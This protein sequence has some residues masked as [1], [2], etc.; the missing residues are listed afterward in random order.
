M[1]NLRER[2][3]SMKP[4][5]P[6]YLQIMFTVLAFVVMVVLS[7]LFMSNIVHRELVQ[8]ANNVLS[9]G[10][11][12]IESVLQQSEAILGGF[13]QTVRRII[14]MGGGLDAL[15]EYVTEITEYLNASNML[16]MDIYG[17]GGVY[18]YF[19]TLAGYRVYVSGKEWSPPP[20]YTPRS[21]PWYMA[22]MAA[23]GSI[24]VTA[25]YED[26]ATGQLVF[27]F[28]RS[29][30]HDDGRFLGV[31][32]LD[33]PINTIAD[34]IIATALAQGGYG[35]L[36]SQ[37]MI[38]LAHPNKDLIGSSFRNMAIP[39]AIFADDLLAGVEI[40]ERRVQSFRGESAIAFFREL[41]NGWYLGLVTP[42]GPYYQSVR[43]MALILSVLGA[44]L[45]VALV[46]VLVRID[47]ARRKSSEESHK[48]S[49]FLAKMSHEMRTPLNAVIGF[50]DLTL[51][52]GGLNEEASSNISK[53]RDAGM[54]LLSTVNDILDISKIEAG[55]LGI[56]PVVY[57]TPSLLNDAITQSIM[58]IG[59]KNIKFILDISEDL[60]TRLYGDDLRVKQILN[61]L[62][63]N[64]FKYTE[65][66]TVELKVSCEREGD[67]VWLIARVSDTGAGIRSEDLGRLFLDYSQMDAAFNRK[68]EGTGLGLS[69]SK[70]VAEQMG[71]SISVES[72]YGKGSVFT[73]KVMQKSVTSERIGKE[74]AD[75]INSF[76]F[77]DIRRDH[78]LRQTQVKL[79]Y[80]RV[81]IVD[82]M[83]ANLVIAKGMMKPYGMQI[84]CVKSGQEAIDAVRAE[85][86][87][88][89]AIFMDHMMPVIDGIKAAK[90]IRE[91][92]GTEYA[93]TVPIIAL[94]AN[95]IVGNE[96]M[97]LQQG[98]QAFLSKPVDMAIL[99]A[100]ILEYVQDKK[101]EKLFAHVSLDINKG[102][103][104]FGGDMESYKQVLRSFVVNTPPLLELMKEVNRENLADYA[105]AVH[106][107]KGS[108]RGIS[109]MEL[110]DQAEALEMAAKEGKYDYVAA[111]NGNFIQIAE[112]MISDLDSM[113]S[114]MTTGKAKPK[115]DKPDGAVLE[116]LLKACDIYDM[117]GVD[118][119]MTEIENYEYESD[120]GLS[121][122]LRKNVEMMNFAQIKERLAAICT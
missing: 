63:T 91:E 122:W 98:F 41:Q 69:I 120:D 68:I 3:L 35:V 46:F 20:G 60:P 29:L 95:A 93:K 113:L 65:E 51:E 5:G 62:L 110:G 105:I 28:A 4:K 58:R 99:D 53:I 75:N 27:T 79:P 16:L 101:L 117:D 118:A 94:T 19:E 38:T 112:K 48:K 102:L 54:T 49:V 89:N 86:V 81:L 43:N 82:D 32:S 100:V 26:L 78:R 44:V 24:V 30:F 108:S 11:S 21:R 9:L 84:D 114:Q 37:D 111:N 57:Y 85:E 55:K 74:I 96:E 64:A 25:P 73:V 90:I 77:S 23:S 88:Y 119:A 15:Q 116:K 33:M 14:L 92:I 70:R 18:G 106:G 121:A 45:A 7:Y 22:A 10:Q 67:K 39:I 87:R 76:Q 115:K 2:F 109:A 17:A 52:S 56:I 61:N 42:Q 47:A 72:E 59:E 8:N 103:G 71:G 36:I 6:L 107:I 31:A 97:F 40:S 66:G 104:R 50:S 34:D 13:S 83:E 1:N 80:A 12:K